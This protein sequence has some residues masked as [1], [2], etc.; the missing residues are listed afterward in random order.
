MPDLENHWLAEKLAYL[1]WSL[2]RNMVWEQKMRD[3][4]PCPEFDPKA[5][6][7]RKP[8]AA[9]SFTQVYRK[10]PSP[11]NFVNPVTFLGLERKCIRSLW[12]VPAGL[13]RRFVLNEIGRQ[14]RASWRH[15]GF[16]GTLCPLPTEHWKRVW[17]ICPIASA[18]VVSS[19]KWIYTPST[20]SSAFACFGV[21]SGSGRPASIPNSSCWCYIMDNADPPY[22]GEKHLVFLGI[23]AE[24]TMG[25]WTTRQ[26]RLYDNVNFPIV[27]SYCSLDINF[28]SKTDAIENAWTK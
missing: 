5:D 8:K 20:I 23:L 6:G 13:K 12:W 3:V 14:V 16:H 1:D 22:R 26:K 17:Q 7:H 10:T 24:A 27:I 9:A 19:K 2:S 11:V 21:T 18:A 4:F 25:I 28:E 15:G